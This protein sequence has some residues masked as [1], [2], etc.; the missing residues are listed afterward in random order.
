MS[1]KKAQR[2]EF[3][4]VVHDKQKQSEATLLH[5][6]QF[7]TGMLAKH[8]KITSSLLNFPFQMKSEYLNAILKKETLLCFRKEET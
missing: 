3:K 8:P 1:R 2:L 7:T 4:D 6:L 5:S